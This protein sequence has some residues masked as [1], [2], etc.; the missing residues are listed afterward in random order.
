MA[1]I[2]GRPV[3]ILG[4]GSYLPKKILSNFDME[5]IVD[6]SDE[7]IVERSGIRERRVISGDESNASM[8]AAA[9][10]EAIEDAGVAPD[11]IDMVIV[12]TNS[13]DRLL[14]GVGPTVQAM[15]GASNCG[16]MDLQ[17]GCPGALYGAVAAAGGVASGIWKN[18]VVIGSEAI[19]R[20]VDWKHRSTCV[21]FGDG[22]GASVVGE[23]REGSLK[24]THADLAAD[25]EQSELITLPAGLAA[26]PATEA[27]VRDRKHFIKMNGAEVFKFVNRKIPRYL[28]NFCAN[29]GI[30]TAEVDWW[31]F[32]QANVRILDGIA[33]RMEIPMEKFVI[34]VDKYGNTSAASVMIGLHEARTDGRIKPGQRVMMCSFGAGMTYGAMLMES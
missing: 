8:S 32:H 5:K 21:L 33:R 18:V 29:C 13:P 4:T 24:I 20:L 26:E 15:I 27:T 14:P 16:G 7:W 30:K 22:A 28:E 2:E 17:A 3:G 19:S 10:L 9:S 6:T 31:I 12:G 34:N 23:Y 11:D 1:A 25:G